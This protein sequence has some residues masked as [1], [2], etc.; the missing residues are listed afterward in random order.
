MKK[1]LFILLLSFTALNSF[2]QT[3]TIDLRSKMNSVTLKEGNNVIDRSVNGYQLV[4]E[5]SSGVKTWKMINP[6]GIQT[7]LIPNSDYNAVARK[8]TKESKGTKDKPSSCWIC[9]R[10]PENGS[11][12]EICYQIPCP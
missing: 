11:E 5:I 3:K 6:E 8:K 7:V 1:H 2:S 4:L 10:Y 9:Y 12:M